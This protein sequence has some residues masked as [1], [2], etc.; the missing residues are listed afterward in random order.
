MFLIVVIRVSKFALLDALGDREWRHVALFIGP[1]QI[2][3]IRYHGKHLA[4][5]VAL[6]TAAAAAATAATAAT[7]SAA[8]ARCLMLTVAAVARLM[9]IVPAFVGAKV[10][11]ALITC[12]TL[13]QTL[14]GGAW[15]P[16]AFESFETCP[17]RVNV[18]LGSGAR[19]L[20]SF[21]VGLQASLSLHLRHSLSVLRLHFHNP[22]QTDAHI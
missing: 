19:H 22:V 18:V 9:T 7:A 12:W 15:F 1:V 20:R 17:A 5:F 11:T 6:G 21:S 10:N 14:V 13:I 16:R 3:P 2:T 4:F 8:V